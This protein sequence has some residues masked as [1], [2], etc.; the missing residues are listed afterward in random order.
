[1]PCSR[2]CERSAPASPGGGTALIKRGPRAETLLST[3]VGLTLVTVGLVAIGVYLSC[4]VLAGVVC[5]PSAQR[6]E[7][8]RC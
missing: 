5:P 8:S 6:R 7:A 3:S 4:A 1:M 2:G